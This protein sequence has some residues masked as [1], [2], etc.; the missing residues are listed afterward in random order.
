MGKW[1]A[2]LLMQAGMLVGAPAWAQETASTVDPA[3]A[4]G[5]LVVDIKPFTSEKELPKKV[6]RQLE[7]GALEWGIRDRQL[8]FTLVNKR[9][10][11]FPVSHMTR[12]G[13]QET[14]SLPAGEYK[15]TGVG[16][17]MTTSFSVEKVLE[18]GAFVN[19][20]VLVFRIEPGKTTTLAIN[21]VIRRD[22]TFAVNF[23]MPTLMTRAVTDAA[24]TPETALNTRGPSSIAWPDYTG[25]L[26]FVAKK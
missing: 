10:I 1:M 2:G 18:R 8:V 4:M 19:E 7:S 24:E 16:L 20:D 13:Q 17:E 9:F 15:V 6:N 14:L 12:Y 5:T 25:P 23:W 21:P 11:D 22:A 3:M 26:K